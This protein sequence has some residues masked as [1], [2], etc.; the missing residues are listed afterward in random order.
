MFKSEYKQLN[1]INL[2]AR[3]SVFLLSFSILSS[4][5][6]QDDVQ[7]PV[8]ALELA[9]D[10]SKKSINEGE[11]QLKERLQEHLSLIKSMQVE[12]PNYLFEKGVKAEPNEI[13]QL[14]KTLGSQSEGVVL[15]Q[16]QIQ[17]GKKLELSYGLKINRDQ[18][19]GHIGPF[20]YQGLKTI[21]KG[22]HST[23]DSKINEQYKNFTIELGN[24][25]IDLYEI[26]HTEYL[27]GNVYVK[28]EYGVIEF[29]GQTIIQK[30]RG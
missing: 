13:K 26:D 10:I 15:R 17:N 11:Q 6:S 25:F 12:N 27:I 23:D 24:V 20:P 21:K 18:D 14:E 2:L 22:R 7:G 29:F 3:M 4:G 8:F 9:R 16:S 5:F 1:K 30:T 19:K 28:N